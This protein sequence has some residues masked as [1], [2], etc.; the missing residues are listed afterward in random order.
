[1]A[2]GTTPGLGALL[3]AL[4]WAGAAGA[5]GP[6]GSPAP[7]AFG[8]VY[9]GAV[10]ISAERVYAFAYSS[11]PGQV[12]ASLERRIPRRGELH[13]APLAL[14]LSLRRW[15]RG[16]EAGAPALLR[17][18]GCAGAERSL[19]PRSPSY[20]HPPA[21]T[22]GREPRCTCGLPWASPARRGQPGPRASGWRC[23]GG[24]GMGRRF[25]TPRRQ[26]FGIQH[27]HEKNGFKV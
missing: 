10:N 11:E 14:P 13:R 23:P 2:G 27:F 22:G 7:G 17:L 26:G 4:L 18:R 8:R 3:C 12:G 19:P 16:R 1:M 24:P 25:G 20:P 9:R 5:V 21:A 15:G 6:G